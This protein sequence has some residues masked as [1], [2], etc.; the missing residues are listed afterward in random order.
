M[1]AKRWRARVLSRSLA[2]R[3]KQG[4]VFLFH[5]CRAGHGLRNFGAQHLPGSA[6]A[7]GKPS[8]GWLVRTWPSAELPPN[9]SRR[10][11]RRP[12]SFSANRRRRTCRTRRIQLPTAERP[13]PAA[14]SPSGARRLGWHPLRPKVRSRYRSSAVTASNDSI[15]TP[16]AP[17]LVL[18]APPFV[19]EE[20][21]ERDEKERA[22]LPNRPIRLRKE[23]LFEDPSEKGLGQVLSIGRAVSQTTD[24]HVQTEYQ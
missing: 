18:L 9:K 8:S 7:C 23:V 17:F 13:G 16:A 4:P 14:S 10:R 19:G 1:P 6:G 24:I 5:L 15:F 11:D 12:E 3:G 22:E 20:M 21:L 2:E